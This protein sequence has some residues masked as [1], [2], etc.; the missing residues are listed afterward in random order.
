MSEFSDSY[1]LHAEDPAAAERLVQA[2]GRFAAILPAGPR[3]TPILVDSP[4]GA[5]LDPEVV[6]HNAGLCSTTSRRS[7]A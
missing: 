6:A 2:A 7:R 3:W 1:H 5:G 4:A